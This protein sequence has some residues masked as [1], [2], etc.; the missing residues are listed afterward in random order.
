MESFMASESVIS[1]ILNVSLLQH[2][3]QPN[4]ISGSLGQPR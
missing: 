1:P 2:L 3:L 4:C